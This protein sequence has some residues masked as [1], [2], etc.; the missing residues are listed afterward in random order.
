MPS[1]PP[2]TAS[3]TSGGSPSSRPTRWAR[4][5]IAADADAGIAGRDG[6]SSTSSSAPGSTGRRPR[7]AAST[8][9]SSAG[10]NARASTLSRA[11]AGTVLLVVPALE[12]VGVTVVSG[13]APSAAIRSTWCA[14]SIPALIPRCGATPACDARPV[15]RSE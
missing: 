6:P 5:N 1:E 4:A 3:P 14:S 10:S 2:P 11:P 9:A 13:G 7:S 12:S 8:R 15:T